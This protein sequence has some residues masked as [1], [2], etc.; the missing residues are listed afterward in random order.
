VSARLNIGVSDLNRP[1]DLSYL[2]VITLQN[3]TTFESK[4]RPPIRD[5]PSLPVCGKTLAG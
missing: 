2:P 5:A 1:L 4:R 3:K